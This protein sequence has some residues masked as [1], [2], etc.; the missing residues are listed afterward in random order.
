M[1]C[2]IGIA[3]RLTC[4]SVT[5]ALRCDFVKSECKLTDAIHDREYSFDGLH[6]SDISKQLH[7]TL[8][9][10]NVRSLRDHGLGREE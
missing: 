4:D 5:W 3:F 7:M 9:S 1:N 2:S 10:Q 8:V 6:P